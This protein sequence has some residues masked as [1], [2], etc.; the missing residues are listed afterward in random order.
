MKETTDNI[1]TPTFNLR[2]IYRLETIKDVFGQHTTTGTNLKVLQQC[3]ISDNGETEWR[4]IP[5][6]I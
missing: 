6:V 5:I 3:F 4:D 2:W 1:W